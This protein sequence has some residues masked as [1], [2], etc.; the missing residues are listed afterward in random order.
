[1][2]LSVGLFWERS[3][4]FWGAGKQRGSLLGVPEKKVT[5]VP[6]DFRGQIGL[7]ALYSDFELLYV[8]QA[9][10]GKRQTLWRRLKSH[11]K[12]YFAD[13]WNRF[14]WFGMLWVR[15]N[16][17]LSSP[18]AKFHPKRAEALDVIEAVVLETATPSLNSQSGRFGSGTTFFKQRR[19]PRLGPSDSEMLRLMHS[20]LVKQK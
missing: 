16:G 20:Q 6:I 17:R 19:D 1:M 13:R 4:V 14:S 12:G 7:Y 18:T 2:I 8:G 9:G 15:T 3:N 5:S 11:Q 10:S